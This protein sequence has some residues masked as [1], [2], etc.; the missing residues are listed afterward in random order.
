MKITNLVDK[1][2]LDHIPA[3][4]SGQKNELLVFDVSS[5]NRTISISGERYYLS[6]PTMRFVSFIRTR[7]FD[8]DQELQELYG[9]YGVFLGNDGE[10][11]PMMLPNVHIS[12]LIC[13]GGMKKEYSLNNL[14]VLVGEIYSNFIQSGFTCEGSNMKD[15]FENQGRSLKGL[16]KKEKV[17][18]VS[19]KMDEFYSGWS[20]GGRNYDICSDIRV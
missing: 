15:F 5:S 20:S 17:V 16:S 8:R 13:L 4:E 11:Y 14:E 9:L 3:F 19:D 18:S 12:G 1:V 2:S 7:R 6:I 10:I